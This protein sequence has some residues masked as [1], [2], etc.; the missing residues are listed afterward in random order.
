VGGGRYFHTNHRFLVKKDR[1]IAANYALTH[2]E[3][4][5]LI[6]FGLLE[7]EHYQGGYDG[8]QKGQPAHKI[9]QK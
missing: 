1:K 5:H 4:C 7:Y 8:Y 2:S 6:E 3:T 9:I